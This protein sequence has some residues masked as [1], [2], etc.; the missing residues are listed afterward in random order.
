MFNSLFKKI[1]ED[2]NIYP[3]A[4]AAMV[5]GPNVNS[6]GPTPSGFLGGGLPGINPA[7]SALVVKPRLK[8]KKKLR[9]K[10]VIES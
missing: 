4:R 10:P 8:K 7:S 2:F 3:R 5:S 1:L 6:T 9:R